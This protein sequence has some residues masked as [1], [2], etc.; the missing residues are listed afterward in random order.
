[1]MIHNN[2]RARLSLSI[3]TSC[4]CC[5]VL[6]C[7]CVASFLPFVYCPPTCIL[8]TT[9]LLVYVGVVPLYITTKLKAYD[10]L[11]KQLACCICYVRASAAGAFLR[12]V[13]RSGRHLL[14]GNR[15]AHILQQHANSLKTKQNK[16]K[17]AS[18]I[19]FKGYIVK[20]KNGLN[21]PGKSI[22]AL[23]PTTCLYWKMRMGKCHYFVFAAIFSC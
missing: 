3:N 8:C 2:E 5:A 18:F 10:G 19:S 7:P 16:K 6:V 1:M 9:T 21:G 23:R 11:L 14:N 20:K 15:R 12:Y 22:H 17:S 4:C 13:P